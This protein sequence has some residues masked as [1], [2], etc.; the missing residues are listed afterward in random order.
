MMRLAPLA[1]L[2]S[3]A[4][5][6]I[7]PT[8]AGTPSLPPTLAYL[9]EKGVKLT[10]LGK[11][12]EIGVWLGEHDGQMQYFSTLP[13]GNRAFAGIL[14]DAS[15]RD[16]TGDLL[17]R[18]V[19]SGNVQP[20]R[21]AAATPALTAPAA[22]DPHTDS[23]AALAAAAAS[24]WLS[25]GKPGSPVVYMVADPECPYCRT[26]WPPLLQMSRENKIELRVIPV[27]FIHGQASMASL[28]SILSAPSP[29]RAWDTVESGGS[30]AGAAPSDSVA[31]LIR[32]N[33]AFTS[34]FGLQ[35]TP[36]FLWTSPSGTHVSLG[37]PTTAD[38]RMDLS[39]LLR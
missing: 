31:S 24:H 6:P 13:D 25:Y 21:I 17:S 14:L 37:V 23:S 32:D 33:H 18:A 36:T 12:G 26:A 28:T 39:A 1:I 7:V 15:G 29:A 2:L 11:D 9:Q 35:S 22:A 27:G 20:G 4:L 8:V 16:V 19:A 5:A 3:A 30:I 34:R 10:F 38:G